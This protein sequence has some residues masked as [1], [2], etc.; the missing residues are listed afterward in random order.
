MWAGEEQIA[1]RRAYERTCTWCGQKGH[2]SKDCDRAPAATKSNPLT[3]TEFQQ[4]RDMHR[5]GIWSS[6]EVAHQLKLPLREINAAFAYARYETYLRYR[7][8][9]VMF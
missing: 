6:D 7:R 9:R 5:H 3:E 1:M 8:S 4:V 2:K